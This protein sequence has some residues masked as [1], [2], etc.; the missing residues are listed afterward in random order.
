LRLEELDVV[1]VIL[2]DLFHVL[3]G[4]NVEVLVEGGG[5][6]LHC[7]PV[8]HHVSV[9]VRQQTVAGVVKVTI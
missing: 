5:F 8:P 4:V 2:S 1:Q 9:Q 6:G 7:Q 3:E